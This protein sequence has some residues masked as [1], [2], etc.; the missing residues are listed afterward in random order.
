MGSELI[1]TATRI[2]IATF[3]L[4]R[5]D[6]TQSRIKFSLK[7][8]LEKVVSEKELKERTEEKRA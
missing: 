4:T 7:A 3:K 1:F 8:R 5:N 6:A 2:A